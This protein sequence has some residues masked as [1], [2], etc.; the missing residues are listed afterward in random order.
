MLSEQ[1]IRVQ[2]ETVDQQNWSVCIA[3]AVESSGREL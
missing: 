2:S 3:E 1:G